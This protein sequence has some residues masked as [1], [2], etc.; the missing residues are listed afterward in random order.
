MAKGSV[1]RSNTISFRLILSMDVADYTDHKAAAVNS[2]FT[3][4]HLY[5]DPYPDEVH[6]EVHQAVHAHLHLHQRK[7]HQTHSSLRAH[8]SSHHS[9]PHHHDTNLPS[10]VPVPTHPWHPVD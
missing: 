3:I 7:V 2:N 8:P 9:T 4:A 6:Q 1:N 5:H 10:L